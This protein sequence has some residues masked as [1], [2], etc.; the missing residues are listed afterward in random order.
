MIPLIQEGVKNNNLSLELR[1]DKAG[2]TWR[3]LTD[4]Q[5]LLLQCGLKNNR[6]PLVRANSV[7]Q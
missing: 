5:P 2:S 6:K 1:V 4:S 3:T 7:N